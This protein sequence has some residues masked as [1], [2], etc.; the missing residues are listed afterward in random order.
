MS[1][2]RQTFVRS[3]ALYLTSRHQ[4]PIFLAG[5]GLLFLGYGWDV[6]IHGDNV[7]HLTG[8][9]LPGVFTGL[10]LGMSVASPFGE[11]DD[12]I[13]DAVRLHRWAVFAIHLLVLIAIY[14]TV[15]WFLFARPDAPVMLTRSLLGFS[16][17]TVIMLGVLAPSLAWM[18]G[19]AWGFI[20]RFT[21]QSN[22]TFPWWAFPMRPSNDVLSWVIAGGLFVGGL[23]TLH[24]LPFRNED[25]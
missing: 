4:F 10:L 19:L 3:L 20:S 12:A 14:W 5:L 24:L 11:L 25:H 21:I 2:A 1:A 9:S 22:W 13:P 17:L 18:P 7:A 23:V 15:A 8:Q 6:L 16:G